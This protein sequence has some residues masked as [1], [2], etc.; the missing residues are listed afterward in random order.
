[1]VILKEAVFQKYWNIS[2]DQ[3]TEAAIQQH[4]KWKYHLHD[5]VHVITLT[6]QLFRWLTG[7]KV[8]QSSA[9][10]LRPYHNAQK[11]YENLVSYST[12]YK[13]LLLY[14]LKWIFQ[15]PLA[16]SI[17]TWTFFSHLFVQYT[18]WDSA[19]AALVLAPKTWLLQSAW[20]PRGLPTEKTP[21]SPGN[22]LPL[23]FE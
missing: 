1:M 5:S 19:F 3:N 21:S 6:K 8:M 18:S 7:L 2:Y 11:H 17:F 15:L 23:S 12:Y 9:A 20:A 14:V 10:K 13:S 16:S 4:L 22:S